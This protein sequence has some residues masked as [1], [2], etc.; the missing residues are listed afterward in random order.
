MGGRNRASGG[1]VSD[2][3]LAKRDR[4]PLGLHDVIR[5][6]LSL[7][8][9]KIGLRPTAPRPGGPDRVW[10]LL[11]NL[12]AVPVSPWADGVRPC[13]P[14][15]VNPRVDPHYS[16]VRLGGLTDRARI[17]APLQVR[18]HDRLFSSVPPCCPI[19]QENE[20]ATADLDWDDSWVD[21]RWLHTQSM[22]FGLSVNV[23]ACMQ[24]TWCAVRRLAW[25]QDP[26]HHLKHQPS[27]STGVAMTSGPAAKPRK[28]EPPARPY[29]YI[30]TTLQGRPGGSPCFFI[31]G[32]KACAGRA[33]A[34][35]EQS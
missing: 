28:G 33:R 32:P 17:V 29:D 12:S 10:G 24:R 31:A 26:Q 34:V 22:G 35:G 18:P 1:Q 4:T 30:S 7:R 25:R 16:M 3:G 15:A 14:R 6:H 23:G 11:K 13:P 9:R 19:E 8:T 21:R 2:C 20:H 27:K 5:F